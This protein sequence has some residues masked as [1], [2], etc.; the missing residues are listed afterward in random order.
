MAPLQKK[1]NGWYCQFLHHGKRH[2]ITIGRV[3]REEARAKSE[4]VDHL[5]MRLKQGLIELPPGVGVV[6]FVLHDGK[7]PGPPTV[8]R[9]PA[10]R[11]RLP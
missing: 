7:P 6:E 8:P 10:A 3:S 2:T 9:P 5:L 4:Q 11:P 1:G